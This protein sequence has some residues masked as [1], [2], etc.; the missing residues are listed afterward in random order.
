M[1]FIEED[2]RRHHLREEHGR[3]PWELINQE[4]GTTPIQPAGT[5]ASARHFPNNLKGGFDPLEPQVMSDNNKEEKFSNNPT[6]QK[7]YDKKITVQAH[8]ALTLQNT[9]SIRLEGGHPQSI[10]NYEVTSENVQS[11]EQKLLIESYIDEK[12]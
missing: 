10:N 5:Y 3:Q 12:A 8:E 6:D 4:I 9:I 11:I 7:P 2:D 1:P